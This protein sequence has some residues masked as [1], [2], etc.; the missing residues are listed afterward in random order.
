MI[1]G[2]VDGRDPSFFRVRGS[3]NNPATLHR[4]SSQVQDGHT[5]ANRL[6]DVRHGLFPKS[7]GIA[8]TDRLGLEGGSQTNRLASARVR[9]IV[10]LSLPAPS[11]DVGRTFPRELLADQRPHVLRHM[12]HE[13][14]GRLSDSFPRHPRG[15]LHRVRVLR[16]LQQVEENSFF[17]GEAQP[18]HLSWRRISRAK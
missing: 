14:P 10:H 15:D 9:E 3:R 18:S 5:A 7:L 6:K 12:G 1:H 4:P 8:H 2:G 17:R 11:Q 13:N 16:E